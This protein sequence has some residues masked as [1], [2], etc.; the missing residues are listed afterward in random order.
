V[1]V[2]DAKLIDP[3][4]AIAE[5]HSPRYRV[6]I[7]AADRS[8]IDTWRVLGARDVSEVLAWAATKR[9]DGFVVVHIE[10]HDVLGQGLTLLRVHG[11]PFRDGHGAGRPATASG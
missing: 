3:R 10:A 2:V 8:R 9:G 1:L 4:D 5:I 6:E 7:I 11:T